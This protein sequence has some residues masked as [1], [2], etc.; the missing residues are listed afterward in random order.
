MTVPSV[1]W[2][3]GGDNSLLR[4]FFPS[5]SAVK[6]RSVSMHWNTEQQPLILHSQSLLELG[7]QDLQTELALEDRAGRNKEQEA[8]VSCFQVK[9]EWL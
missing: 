6:H 2:L 7:A 9:F 4:A 1:S 8:E 5:F 3:V